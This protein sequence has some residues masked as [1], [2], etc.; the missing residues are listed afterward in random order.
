MLALQQPAAGDLRIVGAAF[1]I[2]TDLERVGD[3]ATNLAEYALDGSESSPL[4][5]TDYERIA[6]PAL[7][8]VEHATDAFSAADSAACFAVADRDDE[9]DSRCV[10]GTERAVRTCIE[11]QIDA[12]DTQAIQGESGTFSS[13]YDVL[14]DVSQTL[15]I[16]RDVE[17]IG[18]HAVNVAARTLY[19]IE[20]SDEL[21]F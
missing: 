5:N 16:V 21:L 7:E 4:P 1:K 14:A 15:V 9:L 13:A 8:L 18:D 19:A 11:L 3:L 10:A 2:V 12:T 17:R 20:S 6:A